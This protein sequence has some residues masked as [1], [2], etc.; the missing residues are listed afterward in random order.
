VI[1]DER[2]QVE[3]LVAAL[4]RVGWD[5]THL[6]DGDQGLNAIQ[7]LNPD[8]VI[9]DLGLP[10]RSGFLILERMREEGLDQC[11]VIVLTGM[12]GQRHFEY[13][14]TLGADRY[15][16][17]PFAIEDVVAQANELCPFKA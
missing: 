6:A 2:H 4:K 16:R 8:L 17:K 7:Q 12:D 15:I 9:L 1:E 13:A 5:V 11:R 14:M 3:G 10:N